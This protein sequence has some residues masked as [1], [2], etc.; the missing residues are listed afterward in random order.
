[1]IETCFQLIMGIIARLCCFFN[2]E[3]ARK[4]Q[5]LK[6][7]EKA[8]KIKHEE[9]MREIRRRSREIIKRLNKE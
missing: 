5:A 3:L 4:Q 1:M 6:A 9:A 7:M 2:G 8:D